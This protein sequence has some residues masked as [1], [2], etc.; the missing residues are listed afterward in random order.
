MRRSEL[1]GEKTAMPSAHLPDWLTNEA[2][3]EFFDLLH[4]V[5][6]AFRLFV[7]HFFYKI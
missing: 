6:V 7:E 2:S 4:R 3:K 5:P 1:H